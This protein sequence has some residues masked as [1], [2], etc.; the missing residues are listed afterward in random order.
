MLFM[1]LNEYFF[2]LS[3]CC[4]IGCSITIYFSVFIIFVCTFFRLWNNF[5]RKKKQHSGLKSQK[6]SQ[7]IPVR[8]LY[9]FAA[10]N[11]FFYY[12]KNLQVA[13]I[14]QFR[15]NKKYNKTNTNKTQ[16][17]LK[18]NQCLQ[19]PQ[20]YRLFHSKSDVKVNELSHSF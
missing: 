8:S 18:A 14:I 12:A 3:N 10:A 4:C 9:W 5:D 13:H 16:N 17:L 6:K 15:K 7:N 19:M 2:S 1:S 20:K 11:Q